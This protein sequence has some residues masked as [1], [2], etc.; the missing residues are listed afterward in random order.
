MGAVD[1]DMAECEEQAQGTVNKELSIHD[2]IVGAVHKNMA[3]YGEQ[4]Q[5]TVNK[6]LSI[7]EEIV[8]AVHGEM[9][10]YVKGAQGTQ[11]AVMTKRKR[12]SRPTILKIK[13]SKTLQTLFI[14]E[15]S[16]SY[17]SGA[18][19]LKS[20]Q[21]P[22]HRQTSSKPSLKLHRHPRKAHPPIEHLVLPN[23]TGVEHIEWYPGKRPHQEIGRG[24]S[25]HPGAGLGIIALSPL[26]HGVHGLSWQDNIFCQ[27]VGRI[28]P[29]ELAE[30]PAYLSDYILGWP[31]EGEAIDGQLD[32]DGS[33]GHLINDDFSRDGGS[34]EAIRD[35]KT[36]NS[37]LY[38]T[39]DIPIGDEPCFA[40]GSDFWESKLRLLTPTVR[41]AC[42]RKYNFSLTALLALGL[43]ALGEDMTHLNAPEQLETHL[44]Q[45]S[46]AS[47]SD[48]SSD[49]PSVKGIQ[50]REGGTAE[51]PATSILHSTASPN[52]VQRKIQT[53][54]ARI[55]NSKSIAHSKSPL[56]RL[57]GNYREW[58]NARNTP[59]P[60]E[61]TAKQTE[62]FIPPRMTEDP[63]GY[64]IRLA[65][66]KKQREEL[67]AEPTQRV[68]QRKEIGGHPTD[69]KLNEEASH[70][71]QCLNSRV[72]PIDKL[73]DAEHPECDMHTQSDVMVKKRKQNIVSS[74]TSRWLCDSKDLTC[75]PNCAEVIVVDLTAATPPVLP[76]V[77]LEP[78]NTILF[79]G[80]VF[81]RPLV[82]EW[83]N[84]RIWV[85][86]KTRP[87]NVLLRCSHL[88]SD[89]TQWIRNGEVHLACALRE[90]SLLTE[91]CKPDGTCGLQLAVLLHTHSFI[92]DPRWHFRTDVQ[93]K[94]YLSQLAK[95]RDMT[96]LRDTTRRKIVGT[97]QW[98]L[99]AE[100]KQP[101]SSMSPQ[102]FWFS[103]NDIIEVLGQDTTT[104][105]W[106]ELKTPKPD[107]EDWFVMEGSTLYG[108]NITLPWYHLKR[109][110]CES[111]THGI[112]AHSHFHPWQST[113]EI[114]QHAHEAPRRLAQRLLCDWQQD[115]SDQHLD[116][117]GVSMGIRYPLRIN[118]CGEIPLPPIIHTTHTTNTRGGATKERKTAG[119]PNTLDHWL[120]QEKMTFEERQE[121][122][123]P[124]VLIRD[125]CNAAPAPV[126]KEWTVNVQDDGTYSLTSQVEKAME[127]DDV[128]EED[129]LIIPK[130]ALLRHLVLELHGIRI[131]LGGENIPEQLTVRRASANQDLSTWMQHS[132]AGIC[133]SASIPHPLSQVC[134]PNGSCGLQFGAIVALHGS[135]YP[136]SL[137][138]EWF[139]HS[140]ERHDLYVATL[141]TWLVD[142]DIPTD[143]KR[144][145]AGTLLWMETLPDYLNST[146][147]L[148]P[149]QFWFTI[150]DIIQVLSPLAQATMWQAPEWTGWPG[151]MV[152]EGSSDYGENNC[153]SAPALQGLLNARRFHGVLDHGHYCIWPAPTFPGDVIERGIEG[154]ARTILRDYNR[155]PT[156]ESVT[157]SVYGRLRTR[158]EVDS[159]GNLISYP[160]VILYETLWDIT[161]SPEYQN[162]HRLFREGNLFRKKVRPRK[163]RCKNR[164]V[165]SDMVDPKREGSPESPRVNME[166]VY[167]DRRPALHPLR[168]NILADHVA[169]QAQQ[170][171]KGGKDWV[172]LSVVQATQLSKGEE[173]AY[174][175]SM[176]LWEAPRSPP[177]RYV[178][179]ADLQSVPATQGSVSTKAG[180][181][182]TDLQLL[183]DASNQ[184]QCSDPVPS[185]EWVTTG[186]TLSPLTAILQP[187]NHIPNNGLISK[188]QESSS[189]GP[190]ASKA[191][192]PRPKCR[193]PGPIPYHKQKTDKKQRHR[194][195]RGMKE[196]IGLDPSRPGLCD[197]L[198]GGQRD[199]W[200]NDPLLALT[201]EQLY[202]QTK[203]HSL[204][205]SL[206]GQR[207][208]SAHLRH[209]R[210]VALPNLQSKLD[211]LLAITLCYNRGNTS[212]T[213]IWADV[214]VV[215]E[216]HWDKNVLLMNGE[217]KSLRQLA[218]GIDYSPDALEHSL[219]DRKG[220]QH[221]LLGSL[222][223]S[224][225][226]GIT[227][228][229][230]DG[231]YAGR[232][233]PMVNLSILKRLPALH[234][235]QGSA[236]MH[237]TWSMVE[238]PKET[239][240]TVVIR[241]P[242]LSIT[243]P[244]KA[245]WR[246]TSNLPTT[247]DFA[248][249][250]V[251]RWDTTDIRIATLNIAGLDSHKFE[252]VLA[253]MDIQKI[254][255]MVLQDT[256]CKSTQVKYFGEQLR[257]RLGR[258]SKLFNVAG[259][260]PTDK[261]GTSKP[262]RVGGQ[263]F[264]TDQRLGIYTHDFSPDPTGLGVI[265]SITIS[266]KEAG[267]GIKVLGTYWP[268]VNDLSGSLGKQLESSKPF[269]SMAQERPALSTKEYIQICIDKISDS[270]CSQPNHYAVLAGDLNSVWE[271][272]KG[273][274]DGS[275][276]KGLKSWAHRSSWRH[277]T[278]TLG[279]GGSSLASWISHYSNDGTHGTS[280]IDHLLVKGSAPIQPRY[281]GIDQSGYWVNVSDHRPVI[282]GLQSNAFQ[283]LQDCGG[284]PTG[285]LRFPRHDVKPDYFSIS[286][287]YHKMLEE[288]IPVL[289]DGATLADYQAA[290]SRVIQ[291]SLKSLPKRSKSQK[292]ARSPHKDGWS[293]LIAAHKAQANMIFRIKYQMG[294]G[295]AGSRCRWNTIEKREEG[296]LQVTTSWAE[297]VRELKWPEVNGRKKID[298]RAWA[299]GSSI[300]EW[301][302]MDLQC[303]HSIRQR[304]IVD[305][306][307]IKKA[308]PGR[309]RSDI[310]AGVSESLARM[311][312]ER[313]KGKQRRAFESIQG[314]GQQTSAMEDI[315]YRH[316]VT[317]EMG[318]YPKDPQE[319]HSVLQDHFA[320]EFAI[321]PPLPEDPHPE[322]PLTWETIQSWSAF[323][324]HCAHHHIPDQEE[325]AILKQL[326]KAMCTVKARENVEMELMAMDN[327]CPTFAE[328]E[329]CLKLKGGGTAG[330]PSGITYHT[331][332][333][334]PIEWREVAYKAMAGFWMHHGMAT[335]WKWRWLVPL[336]KKGGLT[337]TDLRPIMLLDVLRK[338]WT[339]LIMDRITSVLHKH[340]VLRA[341]QH[342]Y[343]PKRGTDS[344]NLQVINTLE[345]A[346]DEERTLYGSSWDIKKAFDS[347]GKWLIKLAWKR[348]GIPNA[349]VDWLI[350]LDLENHTVVRSG[351][352]FSCWMKDGV[353]GLEGLDFDA[354]MGCGQGDVSSPLTWVAVFDILLSVLED[355]D[356]H[357]GFRLRKP[358]GEEYAAPDVC[359]ADD[360]QSFA[361]TLSQLQRK[362]ELVSGYAAVTG[363]KIAEGKLRTY[364]IK[365]RQ[366]DLRV[367]LV[368]KG[369]W[370]YD[371]TWTPKWV[372]FRDEHC[373][374]SLGVWY[375]TE[376]RP[377]HGTQLE[378]IEQ[379]L[380][381]MMRRIH[382]A[383]GSAAA[384]LAVLRGAIIAKVAYYGGLSQWSLDE[385]R[386]LDSMFAREYRQVTK[387]MATA[388]EES[389][390][391]PCT[392]GGYGLP[393]I[394]HTIQDRK[395]ALLGRIKDHGDHYT[396]WAVD[397]IEARGTTITAGGSKCLSKICP[398]YW[399]SSVV[400]YALEGD[401][402]LAKGKIDLPCA[403]DI[404]N[405]PT[406]RASLT[407]S[408]RKYLAR[409]G[410]NT[411]EDLVTLDHNLRDTVWKA[412]SQRPVWLSSVL[413]TLPKAM[414]SPRLARGQL[415][416]VQTLGTALIGQPGSVVS[417]E[418]ITS[419]EDSGV[420]QVSTYRWTLEAIQL[421]LGVTVSLSQQPTATSRTLQE[422]FPSG[423]SYKLLKV[424]LD[425]GPLTKQERKR[426]KDSRTTR[427][428]SIVHAI[429]R[430]PLPSLDPVQVRLL[431]AS[432][433]VNSSGPCDIYV[434]HQHAPTI[435]QDQLNDHRTPMVGG[436]A[437]YHQGE[438]SLQLFAEERGSDLTHSTS[439][440]TLLYGLIL[441]AI[442]DHATVD[443]NITIF[444]P[445]RSI[446]DRLQG[447]TKTPLKHL[448]QRGLLRRIHETAGINTE[449]KLY[450]PLS[451]L[452]Q[453][454]SKW[455]QLRTGSY[456]VSNWLEE[457][458]GPAP[459]RITRAHLRDLIPLAAQGD[460]WF[461]YNKATG[462][463][464]MA[465]IGDVTTEARREQALRKRDQNRCSRGATPYW[466]ANTFKLASRV[467]R[468][469]ALSIETRGHCI[470]HL[471][472]RHWSVGSNRTKHLIP[473]S[474]EWRLE[475]HCKI[476]KV[477]VDS[478]DH[479]YRECPGTDIVR[480]REEQFEHLAERAQKLPAAEA[481]LAT[482]L[483]ELFK[484]PD[485][486]RVGLGDLA[487]NQRKRL[488]SAY[489]ELDRPSDR[490]ADTTFIRQIRQL[491]RIRTA[492]WAERAHILDPSARIWAED[493]PPGSNWFV[494]YRG[495]TLGVFSDYDLAKEQIHHISGGKLRGFPDE[496]TAQ[497]A[498]KDRQELIKQQNTYRIQA[499]GTRLV[500]IYT[501]G[502]YTRAVP[503]HGLP[504][505][506]GWGYVAID[507]E[508][509]DT[510]ETAR[511]SVSID[512]MHV[513]FRGATLKSNNTGELT[514]IGEALTWIQS[515]PH[516]PGTSH[517]ICSD[518]S[519]G[520]DTVDILRGT[521]CRLEKNGALIQWGL[522]TL[523]AARDQGHIIQFRKV[524]AHSHD[525]STDSRR[526]NEA[527]AL[528][529]RGR[530]NDIAE[531]EENPVPHPMQSSL[532]I[533]LKGGLTD[534]EEAIC[535]RARIKRPP[536][537][538]IE[539]IRQKEDVEESHQDE[540]KETS[541]A[542][543]T[544][545]PL[546]QSL[547]YRA[548][549]SMLVQPVPCITTPLNLNRLSAQK[550]AKTTSTAR[551]EI[552]TQAR[553][554]HGTSG[555]D[556]PYNR[557]DLDDWERPEKC[558]RGRVCIQSP[559]QPVS[560]TNGIRNV[561][562]LL[563]GPNTGES[564]WTPAPSPPPHLTLNSQRTT[565][566][567]ATL[568]MDWLHPTLDLL[569]PPVPPQRI[570]AR[571]DMPRPLS[572]G[573][574]LPRGGRKRKLLTSGGKHQKYAVADIQDS[575][576]EPKTAR[577]DHEAWKG[578]DGSDPHQGSPN[579]V[580]TNLP[581]FY[582]G[583]KHLVKSTG[584]L[585]E[586]ESFIAQDVVGDGRGL[587]SV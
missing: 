204:D 217:R 364:H 3:V 557:E 346:F 247:I 478:Y 477:G 479:I 586:G 381:T 111:K 302:T 540:D 37:Y 52:Q 18:I 88:L 497:Q 358:T 144:K 386:G 267:V 293:P 129:L 42:V 560:E 78:A 320:A 352:A 414:R 153:S 500:S 67:K 56:E 373:F 294:T 303:S 239:D 567:P 584:D 569:S 168:Q 84:L 300:E 542:T 368:R 167:E 211:T 23:L 179:R 506:A 503:E 298:P 451:R 299:L 532:P 469:P 14:N 428:S 25:K 46:S 436:L 534:I 269:R 565:T 171:L 30:N 326:W 150:N 431:P 156:D 426:R 69:W 325:K 310:R 209:H 372:P 314:T 536:D 190:K 73:D 279:L 105:L 341:T 134:N 339:T 305:L 336:L 169:V 499:E 420:V 286:N 388:Q 492:I 216:Q 132:G 466:H 551:I 576:R 195:G 393:R 102:R 194:K 248:G 45:E 335:E 327:Q 76:P 435:V 203:N 33:I 464:V 515:I 274:T 220:H 370:I 493:V 207:G 379:E 141:Q 462:V 57:K 117:G 369:L 229:T 514:A 157:M 62:K 170:A 285:S 306:R 345:T 1:K 201:R 519:Y 86:A 401:T 319:L 152:L 425:N 232:Y 533:R 215:A 4:A 173:R 58:R 137:S 47:M 246:D 439:Y 447:T 568:L 208:T 95:W 197:I 445:H 485:G 416:H 371:V 562:D 411:Q 154:L 543:H 505:L 545:T 50:G 241:Q 413:P 355:D 221:L 106:Q 54:E 10:V 490:D 423:H 245:Y 552:P 461:P 432:L 238:L 470:R 433:K 496:E 249:V 550:R 334:W 224:L 400:E 104:T 526:N 403:G 29:M 12:R 585:R 74:P 273:Q 531:V 166:T 489:E 261:A 467:L 449:F 377:G 226:A 471:D 115:P 17:H 163:Q 97:L 424:T 580:P 251:G 378:L 556:E 223:I 397:S 15:A 419:I 136:R 240:S 418:D 7:H 70:L 182:E 406:W 427:K 554:N 583:R 571:R 555:R 89:L 192:R 558:V 287:F 120:S 250:Q 210:L 581:P 118:R 148:L 101:K 92:G 351:H 138:T 22:P 114:S 24:A 125:T 100:L 252:E 518:S 268:P 145:V 41:K 559:L 266:S 375:D 323:Q 522:D 205:T 289:V 520:L 548:H 222:A 359:F 504:A 119:P 563:A 198:W 446:I 434:G 508:S 448:T 99:D 524:R 510:V 312:A 528:A 59:A 147:P 284:M 353:K 366:D 537:R 142:R 417:I 331:V 390:F 457:R 453:Y 398:G 38:L 264:L 468:L 77:F 481:H 295:G 159:S 463:L 459:A 176:P 361:A 491:D 81:S 155:D 263:M 495:T 354:K 200:R 362:A 399:I 365:G 384:I 456:W 90:P 271:P 574:A 258:Q 513:A 291:V 272:V 122:E 193:P 63:L 553:D 407:H 332:K 31:R 412:D 162:L 539:D 476:C 340:K 128:L 256:R 13:K 357:G 430:T 55:R 578:D 573:A 308:T 20:N 127:M 296:I 231:V 280:W 130:H 151:W 135:L 389:L 178:T 422:L 347:V 39:E 83:P 79:P 43:N 257:K 484:E 254:G 189:K 452:V 177:T 350:L 577:A 230:V 391:Q 75:I 48:A 49:P 333:M 21:T 297:Q 450:S 28:I 85:H 380:S 218:G 383:R 186:S 11:V 538:D 501:D 260:S 525:G 225:Q 196:Q 517:E 329:Q 488:R 174:S 227:V 529:D 437:T 160:R 32:N 253:Y 82:E 509:E 328:F 80:H 342:A 109:V 507:R 275:H 349:L 304:C 180:P 44:P 356:K 561:T 259:I 133:C 68:H 116:S 318:W 9:E 2:E 94:V 236:T 143:T 444:V 474:E 108:D 98:M 103:I 530:L 161:L 480:V 443:A 316:P 96:H 405:N 486:Y 164:Q 276:G 34:L 512:P 212:A 367:P 270:Y 392:I 214:L 72:N 65:Q 165:V 124:L 64:K 330:G 511:G 213:R 185:T 60:R 482:L 337:T 91:V 36:G 112:L 587:G 146:P 265:S 184:R 547:S 6:E 87:Q 382:T 206:L 283:R 139:F 566:R 53:I 523:T 234:L 465:P 8:G 502:S 396:R 360:L 233:A 348:L 516:I 343:L 35:P 315:G 440:R 262:M 66:D 237:G 255:V 429:M 16:V 301:R 292:K 409:E 40:Y 376:H 579:Q 544:V 278:T 191:R 107:W 244:P 460:E 110:L 404:L 572:S 324:A 535:R 199:H 219:F 441:R 442:H 26:L 123:T 140:T 321:P 570:G 158:E 187:W 415:W 27:Y 395:L 338:I 363:M 121:E 175:A 494:V 374:K 410:I 546:H 243:D 277:P 527:D 235:L 549:P 498:D 149:G 483:L 472:R 309:K 202:W 61:Q 473:D 93:K 421:E 313:K 71:E 290:Y 19:W 475:G 408:Q 582:E 575:T 385:A 228:L 564:G 242:D 188:P 344:A 387:N 394:S 311:E 521:D 281:L 402:L 317:K 438:W 51:C 282:L 181:Q 454:N 172:K 288:K 322:S 126:T 487:E 113:D 183:W 458:K 541:P 5:G 307:A 131:W 455:N